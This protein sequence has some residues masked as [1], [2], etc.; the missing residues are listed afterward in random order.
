MA[1]RIETGSIV[2]SKSGHDS[3]S[4]YL[5]VKVE[6]GFAYIAD[7]RRRKL[8]APKRKNMRHLSLVNR[9]VDVAEM[10]TDKK[11]RRVLWDYNFGLTIPSPSKGG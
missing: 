8:N 4:F 2:W 3:G 1:Q 7:G 5:V 9:T 11:I 6:N 10:D